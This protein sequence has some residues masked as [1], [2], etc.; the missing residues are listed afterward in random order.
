MTI[1]NL[2]LIGLLLCFSFAKSQK[3]HTPAEILAIME[4]SPISYELEVLKEKI[5]VPNRTSDLVYNSY[6]RTIENGEIKLNKYNPNS[7]AIEYFDEAEKNFRSE[8]FSKAR[9][10]Y[11]K[12][13]S[14]DSTY[15]KMLTYIAQTYAIQGDTKTAK[16]WYLNAIKVNCIDYMAHWF[17]SSLYFVENNYDKA[18]DEITIA[19][20][21]NRNNP[22]IIK[23]LNE[24]FKAK[25]I[26]YYEWSFNPQYKLEEKNDETS[27]VYFESDWLGYSLVKAV[28][29]FEPDYRKSMGMTENTISTL[30][31]K[32]A[33]IAIAYT[34]TK[35]KM[36][37]YPEFK[38]LKLA[39][40]NDMLNEYIF[41]EIIL[42]ENPIYASYLT[43]EFIQSIKKYIIEVRCKVKSK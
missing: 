29:K 31:E 23:R 34:L 30:E 25:K 42:P 15:Y 33:L 24:I 27:K 39:I 18:L 6:Y 20:I 11:L 14:K 10:Y 26:K 7:Q 13:L 36:K 41:Y 9:E 2:S 16:D 3:V 35:K 22:R 17:V 19:H 43:E 1:K 8:N 4:K 38:A 21:L 40:E 32:E 12:A 5:P 37:K 28:W